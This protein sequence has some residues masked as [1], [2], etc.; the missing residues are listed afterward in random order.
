QD[1]IYEAKILIIGEGAAG[2]TSL[3]NKLKDPSYQLKQREPSTEGIDILQW[4]FDFEQDKTFRVNLWDF[5]GQE[6]YHATH[7]FFL[8]NRSLYVLV[9]DTRKENTDFFYWLQ[10]VELLADQSPVIIIKNEKD[11]RQCEIKEEDELRG[12]F[13]NFKCTLATNLADNR[14]LEA[15]QKEL[16]HQLQTLTHVGTKL[17]KTWADVRK[18][19]END[20]RHYIDHKQFL[21]ICEQNGFKK[22]ADKDQLLEFLHDLGV[23]LHFKDDP[24]LKRTVILK[25]EWGTDAVYKVLDNQTV[26]DNQGQFNKQDV[27]HIWQAEQYDDMHDEL[28]QLMM[29]FK[30][31]YKLTYCD[32]YIAPQLLS[33]KKPEYNLN[34]ENNLFLRYNYKFMPKGMMTQFI[35]AIHKNIADKQ[36]LVWRDGVILERDDTRAE[37]IEFYDNR[38]VKI[39]IKG[40]MPREL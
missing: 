7:Q 21:T 6:I 27:A 20:K 15:I 8:T 31:C 26:K 40:K 30:L 3:A 34:T 32:I 13:K 37:I 14:G 4:Q 33:R 9:A 12:L 29:N 16:Q 24:L 36:R 39:R 23:C 18:T 10:I 25:P 28:L 11:D 22:R 35:V 1:T 38:E 2:K 17:P 5:G 19:L